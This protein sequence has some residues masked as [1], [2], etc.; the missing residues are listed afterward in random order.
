MKT[1]E[2][3]LMDGHIWCFIC[4][5][6][7]GL[8]RH[9]IFGGA[10]RRSISDREGCWIYLCKYHHNGSSISVHGNHNMDMYVKKACQRK[11]EEL[12]G[13]RQ[14]FIKLFGKNYLEED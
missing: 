3:L 4:H 7:S 6:T 5:K 8:E 14:E 2:S 10:G 9:H 13:D 12:K 11:W 1:G